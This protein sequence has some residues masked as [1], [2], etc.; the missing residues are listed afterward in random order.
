VGGDPGADELE[1]LGVVM[2]DMAEDLKAAGAPR[3]AVPAET[4]AAAPLE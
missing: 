2:D 1:D 3:E 4:G